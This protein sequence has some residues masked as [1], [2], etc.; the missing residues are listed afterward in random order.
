MVAIQLPLHL[1][2]GGIAPSVALLETSRHLVLAAK[3]VTAA[4]LVPVPAFVSPGFA[5]TAYRWMA[6]AQAPQEGVF[7]KVANRVNHVIQ[8]LVNHRHA[9]TVL[10]GLV[11]ATALVAGHRHYTVVETA[12]TPDLLF[13]VLKGAVPYIIG[14]GGLLAYSTSCCGLAKRNKPKKDEKLKPEDTSSTTP[15]NGSIAVS[16]ANGKKPKMGPLPGSTLTPSKATEDTS[17][18]LKSP[19]LQ[20]GKKKTPPDGSK[21]TAGKKSKHLPTK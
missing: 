4:V 8:G 9:T 1:V 13:R 7:A 14:A 12:Q 17:T 5:L 15:E 16:G 21:K 2:W 11:L 18:L 3:S 10:M 20:T 19:V 6:L